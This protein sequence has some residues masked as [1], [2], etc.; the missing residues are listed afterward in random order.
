M[1]VNEVEKHGGIFRQGQ[2]SEGQHHRHLFSVLLVT[3]MIFDCVFFHMGS[4]MLNEELDAPFSEPVF[5]NENTFIAI[6][7]LCRFVTIYGIAVEIR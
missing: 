4:F 3:P 1:L 5:C 2:L 6:A 7:L